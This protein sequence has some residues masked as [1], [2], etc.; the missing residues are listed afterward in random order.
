[1]PLVASIHA[2]IRMGDRWFIWFVEK[3]VVSPWLLDGLS[4]LQRLQR[5]RSGVDGVGSSTRFAAQF[6]CIS[7]SNNLLELTSRSSATG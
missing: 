7:V 2:T 3:Q 4:Q 1:M 5:R 6:Q